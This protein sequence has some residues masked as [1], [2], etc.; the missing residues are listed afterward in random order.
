MCYAVCVTIRGRSQEFTRS[1]LELTAEQLIE[2]YHDLMMKAL[3]AFSQD[4][5][6]LIDMAEHG[7]LI[8]YKKRLWAVRMEVLGAEKK[9]REL[10]SRDKAPF[11]CTNEGA[12][13]FGNCR[14]ATP[15]FAAVKLAPPSGPGKPLKVRPVSATSPQYR[16][17]DTIKAVLSKRK[18]L[19]P[20]KLSSGHRAKAD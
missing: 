10:C 2:K 15:E 3:A 17:E 11:T 7:S 4:P 18:V 19:P 13:G 14:W 1:N 9:A 20:A 5:A 6:Y 12:C 16:I 8:T